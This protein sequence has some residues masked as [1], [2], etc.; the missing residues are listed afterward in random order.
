MGVPVQDVVVSG[1]IVLY[2]RQAQVG[3][4]GPDYCMSPSI[5]YHDISCHIKR[6]SRTI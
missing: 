2:I 3:L 4:H 6:D 5:L 1:E